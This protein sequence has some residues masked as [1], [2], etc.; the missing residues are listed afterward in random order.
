MGPPFAIT[1]A[2]KTSFRPIFKPLW[3]R[4]DGAAVDAEGCYWGVGV[5]AGQLNRFDPTDKFNELG[6]NAGG[7]SGH[8]LPGAI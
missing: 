5:T 3:G 4:L 2:S 6:T 7:R 8:A 1:A